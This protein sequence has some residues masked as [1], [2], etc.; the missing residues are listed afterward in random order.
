MSTKTEL[1]KAY[2]EGYTTE[3]IKPLKLLYEK[4]K[5]TV[6]DKDF[7]LSNGFTQKYNELI[8]VK[9][10]SD[11][12]HIMVDFKSN[13]KLRTIW[14]EKSKRVTQRYLDMLTVA[15]FEE[16]MELIG[17]DLNFKL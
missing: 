16:E 13:S 2:R 12:F 5:R 14:M 10:F 7:L 9:S 8:F 4:K 1:L 17:V 15:D 11:D 3:Y 6:V